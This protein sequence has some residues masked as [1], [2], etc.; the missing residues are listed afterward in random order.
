MNIMYPLHWGVSPFPNRKLEQW[1]WQVRTE[2]LC[3]DVECQLNHVPHIEQ[4]G[5]VLRHGRK[6]QVCILTVK[7]GKALD[8][9]LDFPTTHTHPPIPPHT[10]T[11]WKHWKDTLQHGGDIEVLP[12]AG[13]W[14]AFVELL[15]QVHERKETFRE[16]EVLKARVREKIRRH[17]KNTDAF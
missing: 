2:R 13:V 11:S 7:E 10:H 14:A 6:T 12:R 17:Y 3:H 9:K 1:V 16:H 5:R 15:L 8:T 4:P